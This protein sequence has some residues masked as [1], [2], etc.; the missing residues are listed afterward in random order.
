MKNSLFL[1]AFAAAPVFAAGDTIVM[2]LFTAPGSN[3]VS[4][5]GVVI[6][7]NQKTPGTLASSSVTAGADYAT[8]NSALTQDLTWYSNVGP[9]T[10]TNIGDIV[11]AAGA[12]TIV[13]DGPNGSGR[14]SGAAFAVTLGADIVSSLKPDSEMTLT[15]DISVTTGN[16]ND[17]G[18]SL[19]AQMLTS[20]GVSDVFTYSN[21]GKKATAPASATLTLDST[22]VA[23]LAASQQ[24]QKIIV[25]FSDTAVTGGTNEGWTVSNL[26]LHYAPEPATATLSL[27]A[28]AALASRRKRS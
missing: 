5:S 28:L 20:A 9:N 3:L 13:T 27:L 6:G 19:N 24:Q 2:D 10:Q 21:T 8:L 11:A 14:V 7:S 4:T 17:P 25:L 22:T 16:N 1:L 23:A 12:V 15:F 26:K 18:Q